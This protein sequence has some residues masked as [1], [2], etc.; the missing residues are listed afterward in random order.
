[1]VVGA[2]RGRAGKARGEAG[3]WDGEGR[4]R[5]GGVA[6]EGEVLGGFREEKIRMKLTRAGPEHRR[7]MFNGGAPCTG[8]C[9]KERMGGKTS[10]EEGFA[11]LIWSTSRHRSMI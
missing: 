10:R 1:M 11:R 8:Q 6:E 7:C 3:R 2:F 5:G 9:R 4:G